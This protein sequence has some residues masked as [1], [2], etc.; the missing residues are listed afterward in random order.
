LLPAGWR[1]LRT[2]RRGCRIA[3]ALRGRLRHGL[4]R[5]LL[6]RSRGGLRRRPLGL[7]SLLLALGRLVLLLRALGRLVLG[8]LPLGRLILRL[9]SLGRLILGLLPLRRLSL[10]LLPA[11]RLGERAAGHGR[12]PEEAAGHPHEE[13]LHPNLLVHRKERETLVEIL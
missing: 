4:L 6:L 3:R 11:A 1:G 9:L 13:A 2:R 8:L 12:Q 7:L 10:L 5:R